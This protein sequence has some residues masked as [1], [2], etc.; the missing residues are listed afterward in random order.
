MTLNPHAPIYKPKNC[1]QLFSIY[2]PELLTEIDAS[3]S[4]EV[5]D[6]MVS[7]KGPKNSEDS[8]SPTV[9]AQLHLLS[10]RVGQ[11]RITSEQALEQTN[12]LIQTFPLANK[13]QFQY[14]YAVQQQVAQ[15]FVD[16]NVENIERL[17][18]CTTNRQLED[19]LVQLR[20]QVNQPSPSS[21]PVPFTVNPLCSAAFR[22][23]CALNNA[24]ISKL[25]IT[26]TLKRASS[27]TSISRL[28]DQPRVLPANLPTSRPSSSDLETQVKQLG[29][30]LTKA[31]RTAAK[32]LYSSTGPNLPLSMTVFQPCSPVTKTLSCE[33]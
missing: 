4:Q 30:E 20:R 24:Q 31:E 25:S 5:A 13:K 17:K 9:S 26:V 2:C 12:P 3:T 1:S 14:L 18:L 11:L 8:R 10:T 15:F 16:L 32:Q 7:A 21:I 6:S 33:N 29:E 27:T 28:P 19:G 22:D 23:T